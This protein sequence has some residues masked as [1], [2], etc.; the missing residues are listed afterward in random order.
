M[1]GDKSLFNTLCER[2]CIV[3]FGD[4]SKSYIMEKGTIEIA[5]LPTLKNVWYVEGLKANILSIN[6][7][8]DQNLSVKF[9]KKKYEIY[10]ANGDCILEGIRTEDNCYGMILE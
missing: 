9:S 5:G 1:A 8:C 7:I 2:K 10:L 3:S 6:Q 4:G